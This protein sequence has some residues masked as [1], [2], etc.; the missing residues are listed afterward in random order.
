[1]SN[2]T[3]SMCLRRV[4]TK[5]PTYAATLAVDMDLQDTVSLSLRR[6]VQISVDSAPHS[7]GAKYRRVRRAHHGAWDAPYKTKVTFRCAEI[8]TITSLKENWN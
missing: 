8:K 7:G 5:C 6:A 1:M 4:E 2:V 3:Q